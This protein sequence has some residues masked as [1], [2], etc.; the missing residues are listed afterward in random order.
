MQKADMVREAVSRMA[1]SQWVRVPDIARKAGC[2]T[3]Y[4]HTVIKDLEMRGW[5]EVYR[6]EE[7]IGMRTRSVNYV[8]VMGGGNGNSA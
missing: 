1:H 6:G 4:A 8:R 2:S 5:V 3:V 7:Q